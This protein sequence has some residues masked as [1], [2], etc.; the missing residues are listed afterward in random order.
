MYV[1]SDNSC[2]LT[3]RKTALW[4]LGVLCWFGVA[5]AALAQEPIRVEQLAAGMEYRIYGISA[6]MSPAVKIHVLRIDPSRFKL[7]LL[8]ASQTDAKLRTASAWCDDFHLLAAI[9]AGMF[10]KD[11]ST[12]VGYL[13]VG[14]HIQNG[15]WNRKYASVLALEPLVPGMPA[16]LM[17]DLDEPE[18]KKKLTSYGSVVQNLRLLKGDGQNVWERSEKKWSEAAVATDREG[19]IL[20]LFCQTPLTMWDFNRI[21]TSMGLHIVRGMHLEGGPL[22]SLSI[23]SGQT[24]LDLAG[25]YEFGG[26]ATENISGRQM[27][28]PNVIGV[29][30][31]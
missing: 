25:V 11:Y 3:L 5:R 6:P 12:N 23:R 24:S 19:K 30:E 2:T 20:F 15:R 10:L 9:N 7:R 4:T 16:A 1:H 21:I 26:D 18:S 8:T 22:A 31:K 27:P 13:R 14:S 17:V 29:A 28:I